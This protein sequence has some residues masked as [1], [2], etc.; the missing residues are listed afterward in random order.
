MDSIKENIK[1]K[2]IPNKVVSFTNIT[3]A[4]SEIVFPTTS[5]LPQLRVVVAGA[6]ADFTTV[7]SV[8]SSKK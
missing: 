1:Y 3:G 6:A 2:F 4:G 8:Y 5:V 7:F